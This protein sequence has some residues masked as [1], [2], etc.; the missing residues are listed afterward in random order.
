MRGEMLWFNENKDHGFI[1]TDE[2]ERLS[3][4]GTGFALGR[5]P[6]GRCAH[7]VVIFDISEANGTRQAENVTFE[8]DAA[9][10]HRPRIRTGVRVRR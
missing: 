5:R 1:M 10:A 9:A 8:A 7:Q 3:V 6:Q 2:G 4:L